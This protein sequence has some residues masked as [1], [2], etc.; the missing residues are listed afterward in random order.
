MNRPSGCIVPSRHLQEQV[1]TGSRWHALV[2]LLSIFKY[3][4]KGCRYDSNTSPTP[5]F[6]FLL[7]RYPLIH[8]IRSICLPRP[9]WARSTST[10]LPL[11]TSLRLQPRTSTLLLPTFSSPLLLTSHQRLHPLSHSAVSICDPIQHPSLISWV[12]TLDRESFRFVSPARKARYVQPS[13]GPSTF[14]KQL[15]YLEIRIPWLLGYA[16][17]S[18]SRSP[19]DGCIRTII[20]T[21]SC[22]SFCLPIK[23]DELVKTAQTIRLNIKGYITSFRL[24]LF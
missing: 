21:S 5:L 17:L 15:R 24:I 10:H 6:Y 8:F 18:L 13:L 2:R 14:I 20:H 4:Y 1:S 9:D 3:P 23:F 11:P 7:L 16:H 22:L 19:R 12:H